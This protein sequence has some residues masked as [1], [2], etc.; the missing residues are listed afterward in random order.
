MAEEQKE[1]KTKKWDC[2]VCGYVFEGDE[3]PPDFIC[4][5]CG[6]DAS[7]FELQEV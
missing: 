4:P 3:V 5:M 6:A 1:T 7:H 2:Q